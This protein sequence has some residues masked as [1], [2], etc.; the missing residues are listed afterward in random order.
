MYCSSPTNILQKSKTYLKWTVQIITH[1]LDTPRPQLPQM[2]IISTAEW[3]SWHMGQF[4]QDGENSHFVSFFSSKVERL[5]GQTIKDR[6][7]FSILLCQL[8]LLHHQN[9]SRRTSELFQVFFAPL[10]LTHLS[11]F[12]VSLTLSC[13]QTLRDG[14]DLTCS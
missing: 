2:R 5:R 4:R 8:Y 1:V 7:D 9:T 13:D 11:N 14:L 6:N 10:K 3:C 12:T